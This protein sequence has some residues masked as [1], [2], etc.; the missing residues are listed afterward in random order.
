MTSKYYLPFGMLPFHFVNGFLCSV[1]AFQFDV[2][3][4]DFWFYFF[5]FVAFAFGVKSKKFS[6]PRPMSK[7]SLPMFSSKS[8]M[9]SGVSFKPLIHFELIL[10]YRMGVQFHYFVHGGPLFTTASIEETVLFPYSWLLC[11][12]YMEH[13]CMSLFLGSLFCS[14]DLCVC[15]YANSILFWLIIIF[16]NLNH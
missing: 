14:V 13:I 10:L 1:G 5:A 2:V 16:Q 4:F 3:P 7:S 15:F 6:S 12:K 11:H 8:F 9:A